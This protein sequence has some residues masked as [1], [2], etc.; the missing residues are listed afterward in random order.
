MRRAAISSRVAFKIVLI[1]AFGFSGLN[2]R[3]SDLFKA[4]ERLRSRVFYEIMD[5][6]F[7]VFYRSE[8]MGALRFF[9][10]RRVKES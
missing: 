3:S 5:C 8:C 10:E 6:A 9:F 2:A 7:G 4:H 1:H